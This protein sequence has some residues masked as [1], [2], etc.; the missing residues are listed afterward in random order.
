MCNN[1]GY[2]ALEYVLHQIHKSGIITED[3]VKKII[4]S[5]DNA[6][7]QF[8]D[9]NK[10]IAAEIIISGLKVIESANEDDAIWDLRARFAKGEKLPN[11]WLAIERLMGQD[12]SGNR[13]KLVHAL[14]MALCEP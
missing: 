8:P 5:F 4:L 9:V 6:G 2:A 1:N 10:D 7:V 3:E 14:L 12:G 11:S 13:A